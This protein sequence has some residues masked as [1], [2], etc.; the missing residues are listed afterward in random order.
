MVNIG[1][2][3]TNSERR[4]FSFIVFIAIIGFS[5]ARGI[6]N[7]YTNYLGLILSDWKVFG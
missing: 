1:N 5:L 3:N 6:A 2:L 7:F 4:G